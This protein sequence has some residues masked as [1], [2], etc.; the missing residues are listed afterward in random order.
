MNSYT[1]PSLETFLQAPH[2][3]VAAVA[4]TTLI[5][6]PGGTRR[7]AV[8]AG[9]EPTSDAYASWSHQQMLHGLQVI[10]AHGVRHCFAVI[11]RP[12]QV[13]ERGRYRERLFSWLAEELVGERAMKMYAASDW[14][15]RMVGAVE[16][17]ALAAAAAQLHQINAS[18]SAPTLWYYLTT[19][20]DAQFQ[21]LQQALRAPGVTSR[22]MAVAQ[23][24]GET[25]PP[26]T[27]LISFGKP[28][29]SDDIVPPLLSGELQCYWTQQPGFTLDAP[30]L[31]RIIFDYA[32]IRNTWR[33]DKST[34]YQHVLAQRS[35]WQREPAYVLGLGTRLEGDFWYPQES[36]E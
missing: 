18:P 6:A 35:L 24:Y 27:M 11:L 10:F 14:R 21:A 16:I 20:P 17:P 28:L 12:A 25:I 33:S 4:P 1:P 32:F 29:V 19:T 30:T 9:I 31:R 7:N 23:L 26:A 2:E 3:Q 13:A 8:L 5:Y 15:V 22:D 34:R 36:V